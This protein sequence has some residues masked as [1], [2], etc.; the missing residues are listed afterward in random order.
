MNE[1]NLIILF[2]IGVNAMAF[3]LMGIDKQKAIRHKYRIPE[4]TF[5]GLAILGGAVGAFLGMKR[6]RHKTKHRLFTLGM[7]SLIVIHIIL[8]VYLTY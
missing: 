4:R 6:Y 8:I 2:L 7:P 1:L 3:I 5:W